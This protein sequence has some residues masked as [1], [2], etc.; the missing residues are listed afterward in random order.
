[1][2]TNNLT[3]YRK[4]LA[5]RYI[6][7][8]TTRYSQKFDAG[9]NSTIMPKRKI[10]EKQEKEMPAAPDERKQKHPA[11][12]APTRNIHHAPM[13]SSRREPSN[14]FKK[15]CNDNDAA[16]RTN[17]RISPG[18]RMES[19]EEDSRRPSRMMVAPT[20]VTAPVPGRPYRDF[21]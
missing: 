21:S 18:T 19:V 20:G 1:M 16:A 5:P 13:P 4:R 14:T 10:R 15:D 8:T 3:I 11:T 12:A 17:P 6:N 9:A 2:V 7:I